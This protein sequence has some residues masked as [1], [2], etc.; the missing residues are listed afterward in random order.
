MK[1]LPPEEALNKINFI[2]VIVT[3][4]ECTNKI[5]TLSFKSKQ[6][7]KGAILSTL[8]GAQTFVCAAL[9]GLIY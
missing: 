3:L 6:V 4:A 8:P 2:S 9:C 7:R 5:Y 1:L